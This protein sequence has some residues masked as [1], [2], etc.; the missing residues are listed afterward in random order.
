MN[1]ARMKARLEPLVD[2]RVNGRPSVVSQAAWSAPLACRVHRRVV[3]TAASLE[4]GSP[5]EVFRYARAMEPSLDAIHTA[6]ETVIDPEL[7]RPVTELDM[8]RDVEV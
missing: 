1:R 4:R 5:E 3:R 2:S 8:V 6:L 7:Q